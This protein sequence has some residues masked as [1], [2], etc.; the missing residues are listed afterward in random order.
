MKTDSRFLETLVNMVSANFCE[1]GSNA[2]VC[3]EALLWIVRKTELNDV[4]REIPSVLKRC[5]DSV[6]GR[7]GGNNSLERH[8][9]SLRMS[10][11]MLIGK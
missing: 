5:C 10:V 3:I 1:D 7:T 6:E 11:E 8:A 2:F 4:L 9:C